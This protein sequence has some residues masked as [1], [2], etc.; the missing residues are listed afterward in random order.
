MRDATQRGAEHQECTLARQ[1]RHQRQLQQETGRPMHIQRS[2]ALPDKEH[3]NRRVDQHALQ[4]QA[5]AAQQ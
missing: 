2:S 5:G 4:R 3:Q 1:Q